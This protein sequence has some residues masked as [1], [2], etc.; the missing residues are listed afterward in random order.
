MQEK[1]IAK[2]KHFGADP[3]LA[4]A[5]AHAE[6]CFDPKAK[7]PKSTAGGI[8][9]Y[10]DGTWKGYCEGDKY[11]EDDNI[12][13]A[14]KMLAEKDGIDHWEA[15]RKEGCGGGWEKHIKMYQAELDI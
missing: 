14:T 7:N 8:F 11:N 5:V 10:I 13:C 2:A 3:A 1:I 6:S 4:L 9:Q 15:S 12:Q